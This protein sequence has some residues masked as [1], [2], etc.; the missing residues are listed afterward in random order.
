[1]FLEPGYPTRAELAERYAR[2]HRP[3]PVEPAWYTVMALWKLAVLYEYAHRRGEDAYYQ[4]P[5]LV[6]R[7]LAAAQPRGGAG[8]RP[9]SA[10]GRGRPGVWSIEIGTPWPV[11]P[12]NVYLLDDDP[13]TL[14][15]VGQRSPEA[16][17]DLEA[18]LAAAGRRVEDL[19]RIVL[20][21][22]H[23]DHTGGARVAR[24]AQRRRAVRARLA[25][26]LAGA[27][28][29][30]A[31]RRGR[32]RDRDPARAR[33]G[34]PGR[35]ARLAP[36][37]AATTAT[38]PRST[39]RLQ[40]RRRAR[41]RGRRLRV[42]F[43]PGHSPYDTVLHDEER[44]P[45]VRRRP[46]PAL[47]VD[48]DP[49]P[50]VDGDARN[51]RPRAF[52]HYLASLRAT[53]ALEID[54]ILPGH[55]DRC[56]T[57]APRS[58]AAS[59]ATRG[60]PSRR[61][62]RSPPSRARRPRSPRELK[63]GLPDRTAFFVLCE[64]LG[65]L[66]QLIDEGAVVEHL[67]ATAPAG[68]RGMTVG[69]RHRRLARARAGDRGRLRARRRAGRGA[70]LATSRGGGRCAAR[71]RRPRRDGSP[72]PSGSAR[73]TRSCGR[74]HPGPDGDAVGDRA[75]GLGRDDPREPDRRLRDL[76]G[77]PAGDGR[78]RVRERGRA[79]AR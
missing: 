62:A 55:G 4:D 36:R 68:S 25:G 49:A 53:E 6:E 22:Q 5:A 20:T 23:I 77:V 21:H 32:V 60:S 9:R 35:R 1:M 63:G 74:R 26:G 42:L 73:P 24:R 61:C 70:W 31:G 45:A 29:G 65:H 27:L 69:R 43:R 34:R 78:A 28:P 57:T 10:D 50:P 44:R 33:R 52:A 54:T 56:A 76:P 13:L 47:A 18:G 64:V 7:F 72:S 46:R 66:D 15:D 38:R 37:R 11:G 71:R 48:A 30:L 67:N 51:G 58:P 17:A 75:G 3:R 19:E 16:L 39:R 2:R 12:V 41:V 59:T 79:S 8:A 40:R 14:I